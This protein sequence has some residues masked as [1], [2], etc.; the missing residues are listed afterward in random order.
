MS[1]TVIWSSVA[2]LTF[3]QAKAVAAAKGG[4]L[5]N[6]SGNSIQGWIEN[7]TAPDSSD[8]GK[9]LWVGA[10]LIN[11][12]WRWPDGS[13]IDRLR[14]GD[15]S[16]NFD[17]DPSNDAGPVLW[18]YGLL[19]SRDEPQYFNNPSEF[20]SEGYVMEYQTDR[21]VGTEE[22]DIVLAPGGAKSIHLMGGYDIVRSGYAP[23]IDL[24]SGND[25]FEYDMQGL[26]ARTVTLIDGEGN[27]FV[28]SIDGVVVKATLDG[29]NDEF[30]AEQVTY[31]T[32][33]QAIVGSYGGLRSNEIGLDAVLAKQVT[34]GSGDDRVEGFNIIIGGAG[35]DILTPFERG[36]GGSGND[37]LISVAGYRADLKG[38]EGDDILKFFGEA[39][40]SGGTGSDRFEFHAASKVTIN[41][42]GAEDHIDLAR[43]FDGFEGTV[44]DAFAQGYLKST[45]S[46]GYTYVSYDANGGADGLTDLITLKGVFHDVAD[47]LII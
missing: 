41:D 39:K 16:V 47:Y 32:A 33:K 12:V 31:G 36:E 11:G 7:E 8:D 24:G 46:K 37:T 13:I 40:A 44:S 4:F 42:L 38:Q 22:H 19:R 43:L 21:V 34:L 23:L 29:D 25:Y 27:D 17:N 3:E 9:R 14:F 15:E 2:G 1:G 28:Y 6:D 18:N 35:N 5:F 26:E 45:V 30:W 10:E 20:V